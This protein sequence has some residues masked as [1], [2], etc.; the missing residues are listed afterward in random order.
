[1]I[2]EDDKNKLVW[3]PPVLVIL[4][5]KK[6]AGGAFDENYEDDRNYNPVSGG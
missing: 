3:S 6:T 2:S 5:T 1:M 4:S